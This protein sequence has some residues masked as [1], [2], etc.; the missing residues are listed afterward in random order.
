MSQSQC[1][2]CF[3]FSLRMGRRIKNQS[4]VAS[5]CTDVSNVENV[6]CKTQSNPSLQHQTH[7][8]WVTWYY[9]LY[10]S[11]VGLPLAKQVFFSTGR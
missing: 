8:T 10:T 11:K 1:G 3:S 5:C 6:C 7:V 2:T 9:C 4:I